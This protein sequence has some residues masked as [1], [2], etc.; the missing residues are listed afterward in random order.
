MRVARQVSYG[1]G[2]GAQRPW[3]VLGGAESPAENIE[4]L[5]LFGTIFRHLV[6]FCYK[7]VIDII[8]PFLDKLSG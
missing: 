8:L 5:G 2:P 3:R 6:A 1:S 4:N 7:Y